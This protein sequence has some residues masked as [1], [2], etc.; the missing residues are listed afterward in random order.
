[1]IPNITLK[2]SVKL[3]RKLYLLYMGIEEK[4]ILKWMLK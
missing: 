2:K 1:V 3:E 4:T